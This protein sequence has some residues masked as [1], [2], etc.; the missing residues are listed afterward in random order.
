MIDRAPE[1]PPALTPGSQPGPG[2]GT[3]VSR[4]PIPA[5]GFDWPR[6]VLYTATGAALAIV[7]VSI[8]SLLR[9]GGDRMGMFLAMFMA[10][11]SLIKFAVASR[12]IREVRAVPSGGDDPRDFHGTHGRFWAWVGVKYLV[13]TLAMAA[14]VFMLVHGSGNIR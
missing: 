4:G 12:A 11:F 6:A 8:A 9:D 14:A 5:A 2:T 13:A 7:A 3:D 1:S 10:C